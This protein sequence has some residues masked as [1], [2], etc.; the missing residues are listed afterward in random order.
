M[1]GRRQHPRYC[2]TEPADG[3]LRVR[4]EVVIE[5]W[6]GHEVEVLTSSPCH[7]AERLTLEMPG[8]SNGGVEVTVMESRPFVTADGAIRY[9]VRLSIDPTGQTSAPE[10]RRAL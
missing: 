10:E 8:K 5:Q 3:H 7:P 9:R 2:L 4:E 1:T 6:E